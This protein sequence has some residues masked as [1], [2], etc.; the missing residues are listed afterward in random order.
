MCIGGWAVKHK[1]KIFGDAKER[2]NFGV[3]NYKKYFFEANNFTRSLPAY[4]GFY[5]RSIANVP[6]CWCCGL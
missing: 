2:Y 1:K 6:P 5:V 4:A 3:K